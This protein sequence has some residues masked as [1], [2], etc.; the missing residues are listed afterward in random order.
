MTGPAAGNRLQIESRDP[1][2]LRPAPWNPNRAGPAEEAK[3]DASIARMGMF[4]PI[5]C[6]QLD[7]GT[8]QILG[9]HYRCL[10]AIRLGYPAV[11]V[12]NLGTVPEDRARE[13]TLVDNGR[14]GH[15][16]AGALAALIEELGGSQGLADFLPYD[17]AEL[18]AIAAAASIDLDDLGL[19]EEDAA[20][21]EKP[22]RTA[23]SHEVMRFKVAI[24]DADTVRRALQAVMAD[25]GFSEADQLTNAGDALVWLVSDWMKNSA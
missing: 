13:I 21:P 18:E 25:Q 14:Y 9:G 1:R 15:D 16:D 11:P 6:R 19:D 8:L 24:E 5:I 20:K 17:T 12:I 2:D 23:K 22:P 10:S 4:K 3:L 7:D